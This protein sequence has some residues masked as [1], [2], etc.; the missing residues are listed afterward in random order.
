MYECQY[1]MITSRVS[2]YNHKC[3]TQNAEQ[4]IGTDG[5][6]QT[7]RDPLDDRNGSGL[8]QPSVRGSG[9]SPG[10]ELNQPVFVVQTRNAG[11]LPG[12]FATTMPDDQAHGK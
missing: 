6:N 5:S 8:C 10:L 9:F 11:R 3:E 1:V 7:R 4:E 12:P 2:Q